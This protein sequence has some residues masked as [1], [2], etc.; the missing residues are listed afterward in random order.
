MKQTLCQ[1]IAAVTLFAAIFAA[2]CP[3]TAAPLE[4]GFGV[5]E[6]TPPKPTRMAGYFRERVSQ[7]TLDPL[8]AKAVLLRQGDEQ[9]VMVF[10]DICMISPRLCA[11]ARAAIEKSTGLPA[12]NTIIAATHAHTGPLYCGAIHNYFHEKRIRE[13]GKDP[14]EEVDFTAF[15]AGRIAEAVEK[16]RAD[17]KPVKIDAGAAQQQGLSFNR[18]F[19]MKSGPVRFNP[20]TLNPDIVKA[21]G[22]IDPEVGLLLFRSASSEKKLGLLTVFALHLD[23]VGGNQFSADYPFF[24][25]ES[26]QKDFGPEFVSLFGIGTCGDINHIDVTNKERLKTPY[27]GNTLAETVKKA[28][29]DLQPAASPSLAVGR[30]VVDAPIQRY[31]EEEVAAAKAMMPQVAD[32]K[33]PFLDRVR[34][35]KIVALQSRGPKVLPLEIQ[36]VRISDDVAIVSLPG[37]IFVDLGLAVKK[38]SPFKHTIV[39]EL[40]NDAPGYIPTEKAFTEGSYETVNSRVQ[41]GAG[42]TMRDAAIAL[43]KKM[44]NAD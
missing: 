39:F 10:C 33:V 25:S 15:A 40:A 1:C 24:L 43:L 36:V 19:H 8:L 23:T 35:Y 31:T 17:L 44:K 20:G 21:A 16:A 7:G 9:A 3:V 38:N 14:L 22:P 28:I 2:P 29:P 30:V 5:C 12:A 37:E 11:E 26:L 34:C 42:E 41:S 27:I 18:R 13:E 32:P 4:A 6:I